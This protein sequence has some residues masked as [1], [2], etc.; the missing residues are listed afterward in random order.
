M[1]SLITELKPQTTIFTRLKSV[2][3]S[4]PKLPMPESLISEE[5]LKHLRSLTLPFCTLETRMPLAQMRTLNRVV[6]ATSRCKR[7][8]ILCIVQKVSL[9]AT[10]T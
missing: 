6:P 5:L 4:S 1:P 9:V 7:R 3:L 8:E 2:L 10:V